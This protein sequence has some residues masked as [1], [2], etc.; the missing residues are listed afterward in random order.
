MPTLLWVQYFLI[1]LSKYKDFI[2]PGTLL[3][4]IKNLQNSFIEKKKLNE[5][6]VPQ[7]KKN[8]SLKDV[9]GMED[10]PGACP[11]S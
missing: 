3:K 7:I 10:R 11:A 6:D 1:K 4:Q 8:E 9:G 5:I 2:R